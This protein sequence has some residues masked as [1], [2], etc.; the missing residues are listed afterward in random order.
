ML[1]QPFKRLTSSA[2]KFVQEETYRDSYRRWRRPGPLS[3]KFLRL[4][5]SCAIPWELSLAKIVSD[6]ETSSLNTS[7]TLYLGKTSY[8]RKMSGE[9]LDSDC[10]DKY[11]LTKK[12]NPSRCDHRFDS[13]ICFFPI[14]ISIEP[15][16]SA[17]WLSREKFCSSTAKPMPFMISTTLSACDLSSGEKYRT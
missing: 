12:G 7:S 1:L 14:H 6:R 4:S 17:P 11:C 8:T 13:G 9:N 5:R 16:D 10:S 15:V 2:S 3:R